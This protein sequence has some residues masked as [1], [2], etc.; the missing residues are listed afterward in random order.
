MTAVEKLY[1]LLTADERFRLWVEA[2]KRKDEQELDRLDATCP[3]RSYD[4]QDYEYSHKKSH[5]MVL[6]LATALRNLSLDLLACIGLVALLALDAGA[7]PEREEDAA[8]ILQTLLQMRQARREGWLRFCDRIGVDPDA[9]AAPFVGDLKW[10][11]GPL[12]SVSEVL[13]MHNS[14][15]GGHPNSPTCGHFK[16]LH[17]SASRRSLAAGLR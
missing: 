2:M 9:I 1:P 13:M 4:A 14:T 8:R 16:F 6:A 15:P 12:I 7:E 11:E 17:L 3:R 5:F 10:I